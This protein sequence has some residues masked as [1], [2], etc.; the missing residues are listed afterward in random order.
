[1]GTVPGRAFEGYH[2]PGGPPARH[3][4]PGHLARHRRARRRQRL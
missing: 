4:R 2:R 1:M 3:Q